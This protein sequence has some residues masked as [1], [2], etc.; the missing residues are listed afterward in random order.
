MN[1]K[2]KSG[3]KKKR[4]KPDG[5]AGVAQADMGDAERGGGGEGVG[6]GKSQVYLLVFDYLFDSLRCLDWKASSERT[7]ERG[8]AQT[9]AVEPHVHW[10]ALVMNARVVSHS[11][12][13]HFMLRARGVVAEVLT[14]PTCGVLVSQTSGDGN[15]VFTIAL[16][17]AGGFPTKDSIRVKAVEDLARFMLN[18]D[19]KLRIEEPD[20]PY[21]SWIEDMSE[22]QLCQQI[23]EQEGSIFWLEN[24][25]SGYIGPK[26]K[27]VI[28]SGPTNIEALYNDLFLLDTGSW[29]NFEKPWNMYTKESL[30]GAAFLKL[31]FLT[32][33]SSLSMGST[34]LKLKEEYLERAE[35]MPNSAYN[36]TDTFENWFLPLLVPYDQS[37]STLPSSEP[38]GVSVGV[39][40]N[41]KAQQTRMPTVSE[42]QQSKQWLHITWHNFYEGTDGAD[43]DDNENDCDDDHDDNFSYHDFLDDIDDHGD[44]DD[45]SDFDEEFEHDFDD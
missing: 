29:K 30:F 1:S 19:E 17:R 12:N 36:R 20:G 35:Y 10:L 28:E 39:S 21:Q 13:A 32:L 44:N 14:S 25:D 38:S 11:F 16:S 5:L 34:Y 33:Q 3:G 40:E 7:T 23:E 6:R 43:D 42:S 26:G 41:E 22:Q 8:H 2:C 4:L 27:F 37:K 9:P 31:A 45:N 15:N 24:E 18:M